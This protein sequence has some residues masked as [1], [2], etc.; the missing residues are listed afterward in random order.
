VFTTAVPLT[1]F[2]GLVAGKALGIV[3]AALAAVG[4]GIAHRPK[5]MGWRDLGALCL[6]GGVGFTVSLLITELALTGEATEQAK[7]A[8][9]LASVTAA[10]TAAALLLRRNRAHSQPGHQRARRRKL[11]L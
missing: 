2:A 8:V 1:V 5:G 9:L 11:V 4:L 3:G 10:L 6:L 7:A